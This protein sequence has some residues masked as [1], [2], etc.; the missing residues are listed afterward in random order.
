MRRATTSPAGTGDDVIIGDSGRVDAV[1]T[2]PWCASITTAPGIGG[3][4]NIQAGD[5]FDVVFGGA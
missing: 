5:G 1:P 2:R 4:D 3:G